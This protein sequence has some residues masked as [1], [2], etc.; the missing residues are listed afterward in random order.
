MV[1]DVSV[2]IFPKQKKKETSYIFSLIISFSLFHPIF[3]VEHLGNA[4]MFVFLL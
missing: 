1:T 2:C 3:C 4:L